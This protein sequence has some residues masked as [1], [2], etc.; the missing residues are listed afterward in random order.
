MTDSRLIWCHGSLAAPWGRK[1][2]ALARTAGRLGLSMEAPDF[3]DLDGPDQRVERLADA[4]AQETRPVI[5][6]GSSMGGYVA[7]A[8]CARSEVAALFLVAPA[9]FLPGYA[10]DTF[11]GLPPA[12]TV[13]HGWGDEVVP[14]DNVL[15]FARRHRA[16]LHILDDDH[17]LA[18]SLERI[19]L[20]FASFLES[21]R[22]R[23]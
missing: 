1:S 14:V 2:T 6:A 20:L 3:R 13:V 17:S 19:D 15:R 8:A 23:A 9:F 18:N 21:C 16:S 22:G 12:V 7:A 11:T 4:L 10:L 5:L